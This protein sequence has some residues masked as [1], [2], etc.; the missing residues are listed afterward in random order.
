MTPLYNTTRIWADAQRDCC[1][2]EYRWRPLFN[3]AKFG[4]RPLLE[5]RTVKL[6]RCETSWNL[7][8]CPKLPNQSQ[9]LVGQSLPYYEDIC[10]R[11]CCLTI[12]FPIV[13]TCLSC[14]DT[15]WQSCAMAPR[16]RFF[17]NFCILY[18][19]RAAC[20]SSDLHSKFALRPHH[21]WKY[22]RHPVSDRWD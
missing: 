9:P 12:F 22:G 2:A 13:D 11:Y 21:M 19:Q 20:S 1:P 5:C 4:W 14:E 17:G 16:W 15:A 8:G 10:R 18:F 6:P 3:T 7:Q